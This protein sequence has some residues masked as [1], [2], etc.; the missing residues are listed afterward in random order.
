MLCGCS[1]WGTA[2]S[3]FQVARQVSN[4]DPFDLIERDLIAG[5]VVEPGG[6]RA[7]VRRH[8][9]RVFERAAGLE[10]RGDAGRAEDM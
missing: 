8:G 10:I 1:T 9:L 3:P 4:L 6:T 7:F 2:M 5:T